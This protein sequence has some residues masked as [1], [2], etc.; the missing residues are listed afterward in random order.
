MKR[1]ILLATITQI[2]FSCKKEAEPIASIEKFKRINYFGDTSAIDFKWIG[3]A[4]SEKTVFASDL[5]YYFADNSGQLVD[6][7]KRYNAFN[8]LR[9]PFSGRTIFAVPAL[10]N[11]EDGIR[12]ENIA[13]G[14]AESFTLGKLNLVDATS[15]FK[16]FS[17]G[18]ARK[19]MN[20]DRFTFHYMIKDTIKLLDFIEQGY[21]G[22]KHINTT[23]IYQPF[24]AATT[25]SEYFYSDYGIFIYTPDA[26]KVLKRYSY[27]G[28]L[29]DSLIGISNIKC[30]GD[31]EYTFIAENGDVFKSQGIFTFKQETARPELIDYCTVSGD[32][33]LELKKYGLN[34]VNRKTNTLI[35]TIPTAELG[36]AYYSSDWRVF[37][38]DNIIY[39]YD[40]GYEGR[41]KMFIAKKKIIYQ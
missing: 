34:V 26:D 40:K 4:N 23:N 32:T 1:L 8:P 7:N 12:F 6:L 36:L 11:G 31:N 27:A 13:T 39:L 2:L 41:H 20:Y 28:I 15:N 33:I 22:Y 3:I 17:C 24:S 9:S 21:Q 30:D 18:L 19:P 5:G 14:N 37:Y 38:N 29:Q 16:F 10:V 35:K 25:S